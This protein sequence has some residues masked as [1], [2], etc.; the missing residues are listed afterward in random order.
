MSQGSFYQSIHGHVGLN[1][2]GHSLG[3]DREVM[4][5]LACIDDILAFGRLVPGA[6]GGAMIDAPSLPGLVEAFHG[7]SDLSH[8]LSVRVHLVKGLGES[9]DYDQVRND[10]TDFSIRP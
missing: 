2:N 9:Y 3:V 7:R 6:V 10:M 1:Q 5:K 4:I 8:S